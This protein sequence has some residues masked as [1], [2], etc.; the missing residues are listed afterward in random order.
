MNILLQVGLLSRD[1][2]AINSDPFCG[3]ALVNS[4]H[5]VTAAHCTHGKT[6]AQIA[7]TVILSSWKVSR[8]CSFLAQIG[9]H[10]ITATAME[11]EQTWAGVEEVIEHPD[12][13]GDVLNDIAVLR[14]A[15]EVSKSSI[16]KTNNI[17]LL[18]QVDLSLFSP[19]CIPASS[20]GSR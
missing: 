5:I 4:R 12:Y 9:D 16:H 8:N 19:V 14:L 7:V 18:P 11:P 15:Q 20:V 6:A 2:W 10:N 17:S 1:G 3:G 13:D